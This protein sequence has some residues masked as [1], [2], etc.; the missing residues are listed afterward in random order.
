LRALR[1]GDTPLLGTD[2]RILAGQTLAVHD[3]DPL[4]GATEAWIAG[5]TI[6]AGPFDLRFPVVVFEILYELFLTGAYVRL[7][8]DEEGTLSGGVLGGAASMEQLMDFLRTAGERA[9]ADFVGLIGNGLKD[10]ADLERQGAECTKMS[11]AVTFR[12]VT[13]FTF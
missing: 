12:A 2:N 1:G 5:N 4:L 13:A 6:E 8:I 10:S 7:A 9:N 11:M 3:T